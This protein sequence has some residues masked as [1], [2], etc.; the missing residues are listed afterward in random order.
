MIQIS[1]EMPSVDFE[2]NESPPFY[3]L[4]CVQAVI[5]HHIRERLELGRQLLAAGIS[6]MMRARI[7]DDICSVQGTR[8]MRK[9]I[10]VCVCVSSY[11]FSSRRKLPG[12]P[13]VHFTQREF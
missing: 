2:K 9:V 3:L 11:L 1:D 13:T 4:T 6:G 12:S 10:A 7:E 8:N 5:A